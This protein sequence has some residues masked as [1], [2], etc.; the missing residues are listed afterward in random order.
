M[1]FAVSTFTFKECLDSLSF[2][3]FLVGVGQLVLVIRE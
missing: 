1:D 2:S 3:S